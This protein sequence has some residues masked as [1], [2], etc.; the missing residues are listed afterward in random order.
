MSTVSALPP[1]WAHQKQARDLGLVHDGLGIFFD[2]GTGKSRT[3]IEIM[4]HRF[5]QEKRVMRTLILAPKIVLPNWQR[6]IAKYSK[7]HPRD[8]VV[9]TGAGRRREKDFIEAANDGGIL[10]RGRIFVTNF[11]ALEMAGLFDLLLQ[12]RPEIMVADEAHRLKN[13]ESKR[14]KAAIR[15]A[16]EAPY[17]YPLTGSPILNSAMDVFNIFRFL[18]RGE[19]FGTNFWRFRSHWFEDE[20]AAWTG[21][22]GHFPSYVPRPHAYAEFTRLISQKCVY[23]KKTE[24]LD[25]PPLVK[26]QVFVDL[27][28]E[29]RKLYEQ[30]KKDY[31]AWID[32]KESAG[33]KKAVVAQLAVVR[34]L[35]LQQIITGFAN[36]DDKT[37]HVIKDNPRLK[38]LKEL[39]EE[40]SGGHKIIVWSCFHQNY[41]DIGQICDELKI[42]Y[43]ML[44]GGTKDSERQPNV[45][46]FNNDPEVRVLIGN[47]G[48][49]GIGINLIA[50]DMSIYFS[51][52]FSLEHDIQS[53]A[54][55]YRGGS[56]IHQKITRID[57]VATDTIDDLINQA[58]AAKKDIGDQILSWNDK[59]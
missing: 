49:G 43:V 16:D 39:L 29:Q 52:N 58:L 33:E 20:N 56:E 30:M 32:S 51:K 2:T 1:L 55:N 17:K 10:N 37:V 46:A 5:A 27:G 24:C 31:I 8:V 18:D 4:R 22:Q 45:D 59:I 6:E 38:C 23:A 34:A 41:A 13:P 21:K 36:A 26:T 25:L 42:K 35:R 3:M 19:T 50:S 28:A 12:W 14:A 54:R 9:L 15:L 48:A 57:L 40:H 7:I 53:E 11:E 44:H 47:Q